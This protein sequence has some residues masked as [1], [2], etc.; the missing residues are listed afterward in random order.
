MG[1]QMLLCLVLLAASCGV[2]VAEQG[3]AG[4]KT[5]ASEDSRREEAGRL[6]ELAVSRRLLLPMDLEDFC[7]LGRQ[8][9]W[10]GVYPQC[11]SVH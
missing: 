7:V 11:C 5:F 1:S 10:R 3:V 2:A 9:T 8:V 6:F 4:R